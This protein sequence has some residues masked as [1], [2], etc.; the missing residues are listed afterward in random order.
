[1]GKAWGD[2]GCVSNL[3]CHGQRLGLDSRLFSLDDRSLSMG[4]V[5]YTL[6]GYDSPLHWMRVTQEDLDKNFYANEAKA[7]SS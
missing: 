3:F 7:S 1:M 4:F 6:C 2:Q 5:V